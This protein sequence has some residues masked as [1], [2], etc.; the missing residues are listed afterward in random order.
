MGASSPK[1]IY[2][3]A[4][5]L[6]FIIFFTLITGLVLGLFFGN[7]GAGFFFGRS[8]SGELRERLEQVTRD[9]DAAIGSQRE[10]A[11]RASRLQT[12]LRF[13]T[14]HARNLEEGIR[15]FETRTGSLAVQ[16][17]GIIDESGKLADGISRAQDSLEE[18]RLLLDELGIIIRGLPGNLAKEN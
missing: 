14:E 8:S 6:C 16:L 1:E 5:K 17:D 7:F 18:S 3:N 12:E 11:E 10:A 4:K 2:L 13:L 9:L 15:R